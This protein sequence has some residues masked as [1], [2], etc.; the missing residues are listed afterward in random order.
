MSGLCQYAI[1][2]IPLPDLCFG[3]G[4]VLEF[5][6]HSVDDKFLKIRW[7]MVGVNVVRV[8]G[9]VWIGDQMSLSKQ[10]T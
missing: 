8:R 5:M 10:E 6:N 7:E 3:F 4:M 9:G 2:S 1:I